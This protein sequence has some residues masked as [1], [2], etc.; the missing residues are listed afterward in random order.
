[1]PK[2]LIPVNGIPMIERLLQKFPTEWP[3]TFV[4]AENHNPTELEVTLLRLR[5]Q[6]KII[7]VPANSEGPS[8]AIQAAIESLDHELP[9]LISYCDYGLKWDPWDFADYVKNTDCDSCVVSYRGFHAHYIGPQMYAYSRLK[10]E[11][12]VQVKEKGSFTEQ[13]E[14]EYASNGAYYFKKV[15]DLKSALEYQ[16]KNDIKMNNEFYTSL[17]IEALLQMKPESQC[18]VYEVD[19]FYQ[20]GTPEDLKIFEYWEKT[21]KNL[22]KWGEAIKEIQIRQILMP[23]AGLGSR[24]SQILSQ[25][26]PVVKLDGQPMYRRA[27]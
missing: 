21:F 1:M 2:P 25:P 24:I 14:N 26:K 11:R 5:P 15:S 9:V 13:R 12:V 19:A 20:W 23:M 22:N 16:K 8:R 17:T 27:L 10:G 4:L 18:R 3:C 6:S 7:Y